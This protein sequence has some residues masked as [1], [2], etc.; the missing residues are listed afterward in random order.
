MA[1]AL[2]IRLVI[3][4]RH[5]PWNDGV[6][7]G[8]LYFRTHTRFDPLVAG[9]LLAVVHKRYGKEHRALAGGAV[10]PR[11][12]RASGARA[13]CGCCSSRRCS[14]ADQVQLVHVF[15]WGTVTS[16]MYLASV[17]LALYGEGMVCRWLA[18]P[19]FRRMA[20]VGYGVYLVHIPVIDHIMVPAARAAQGRHWSMLFVWPAVLVATMSLSLAVGYVLHVI[21]E[22]PA[23]RLR[24]RFA[25]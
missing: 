21:V 14:A 13:A 24:D 20:T 4:Y 1:S 7:Y 11:A 3:F 25:G 6:L 17:P 5:R 18:A 15:A 16:L 12:A 9:I 10:P 19:V 22:K 23:L 2:V 8:A